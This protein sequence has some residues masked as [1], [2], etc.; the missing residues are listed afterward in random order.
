ME[1]FMRLV[2]CAVAGLVMLGTGAA[3][4][5]PLWGP[6]RGR[7]YEPERAPLW[8]RDRD[9]VG[10]MRPRQIAYIVE[11]LGLDPVGPS[12]RHGHLLV[13]RA[14]D[15]YGRVMQVTINI[16]SGAVVSVA[17][18]VAP[19][20][21]NGG[22]YQG[23]RPYG[24]GPYARPSPDDDDVEY[25][26][27]GSVMALPPGADR[28]PGMIPPGGIPPRAAA[29]M[30]YPPPVIEAPRPAAKSATVTPAKP[31]VPRKRPDAAQAAKKAEPGSVAPLPATP[32]PASQSATP[33][34]PPSNAMPPV[35]PLE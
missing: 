28:P 11:S 31:P 25:A 20:P 24:P 22:P 21:A 17:P 10:P 27:R 26:P 15:D 3:S 30:P 23:Y 19:L 14:T 2:A 34:T 1:V 29:V 9:R 13:Q 32:A 4:A 18:A 16:D 35:A 5:Q 6:D 12:R 33:A 7:F 8:E